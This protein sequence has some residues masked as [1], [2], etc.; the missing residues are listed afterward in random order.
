M[1]NPF[2][3]LRSSPRPG[4]GRKSGDAGGTDVAPSR[5]VDAEKVLAG[6]PVPDP[7]GKAGAGKGRLRRAAV[8]AASRV[9]G[10]LARARSAVGSVRARMV[11]AGPRRIAAVVLAVLASAGLAVAVTNIVYGRL[12]Q[13][14]LY[15]SGGAALT[16]EL[17][18]AARQD[19]GG[20]IDGYA[21]SNRALGIRY[22]NDNPAVIIDGV[23]RPGFRATQ[24][25]ARPPLVLVAGDRSIT[26]RPARKYWFMTRKEGLVLSNE[27][28]SVKDLERYLEEYVAKRPRVNMNVVGDIIPGRHVA[29]KMAQHGTAYP[30]RSI[31]PAVNDADVVFGDLECPLSD[32]V[33]PPYSGMYFIAPEKT[34]QGL[35]MLGLD[36]VALANNHSTNFGRPAF[37]DTLQVLKDSGIQYAG[38]GNDY[39]E[40]HRP[41]I[42]EADGVRFAFLSYNSIT[43]SVDATRDIPGT[44][45]VSILPYYPDDPVQIQKVRD[46][47]AEARKRADVVVAAFHWS[48]E[49][50]YF[51]SPSMKDLTYAALGAGADMVIGSHPHTVQPVEF[52]DGKFIAYSLGNFIF[53]QMQRDQTREG[54]FLKCTFTDKT[55]TRVEMVPY[56]IYDYS[57]PRVMK[58]K[59]GQRILD[60]V[61][62]ISGK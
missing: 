7:F 60:R 45:W 5:L 54:F 11:K 56:K 59:S 23:K 12:S 26:L 13:R 34:V 47:I 31:A 35:K 52:H 16:L 21:R 30:F 51:P 8:L 17:S 58:G 24:V 44:A 27:D 53:D 33:R 38:G 10:P 22:G 37:T 46:D 41:A 28:A 43:G 42:V 48:Q 1:S 57:Q 3:K 20:V 15:S 2:N 14:R 62:K 19:L 36:V 49:D 9:R 25:E 40:A 61:L 4:R 18:P 32:S 50:V 6:K 55:L 29:E 39:D